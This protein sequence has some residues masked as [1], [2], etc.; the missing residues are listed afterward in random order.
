LTV[1]RILQH[2]PAEDGSCTICGTSLVMIA[3]G[4]TCIWR[5]TP[6]ARSAEMA[7]EPKE[8]KYAVNDAETISARLIELAKERLPVEAAEL[9]PEP[10]HYNEC[11]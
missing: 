2:V 10:G 7:P 3:K 6:D 11:G 8:R 4:Y 9:R 1:A 5:D